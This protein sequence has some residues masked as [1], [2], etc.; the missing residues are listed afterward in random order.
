MSEMFYRGTDVR[1]VLRSGHI[2]SAGWQNVVRAKWRDGWQ[3]LRVTRMS[4]GAEMAVIECGRLR[5]A[6]EE[7]SK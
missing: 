7:D 5:F 3:E 1:G 4:D 6:R 2:P